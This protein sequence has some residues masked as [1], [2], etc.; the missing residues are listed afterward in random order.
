M[1]PAHYDAAVSVFRDSGVVI[2]AEGKRHLG[3]A[4]GTASFV[5]LFVT[6]KVSVRKHE[7]EVLSDI[8]LTQPHAVYAAFTHGII[9]SS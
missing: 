4:L 9:K 2:T 1:K 8:S 3:A 5:T 7:L 6:Q